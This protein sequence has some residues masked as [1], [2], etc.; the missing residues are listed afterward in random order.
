[1]VCQTL[2]VPALPAWALLCSHSTRVQGRASTLDRTFL[3]E[4]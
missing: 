2:Q 1:M 3:S 4:W